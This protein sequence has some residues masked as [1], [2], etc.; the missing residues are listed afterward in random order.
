MATTGSEMPIGA[1]SI[2]CDSLKLKDGDGM[3]DATSKKM[4]T[5]TEMGDNVMV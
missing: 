2:S 1:L 5:F 4:I 3:H